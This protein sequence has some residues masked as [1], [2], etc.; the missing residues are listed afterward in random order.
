MCRLFSGGSTVKH[1][2]IGKLR[3]MSEFGRATVTAKVRI[4]IFSNSNLTGAG[5]EPMTSGKEGRYLL[6]EFL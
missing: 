1:P 5:I 2:V 6:L 3:P 4:I